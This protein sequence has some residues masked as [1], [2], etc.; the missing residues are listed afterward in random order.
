MADGR[1]VG[2]Y[3]KCHN[4]PNNRPTETQ[5]GWSHH[6]TSSTCPP[7]FGCYGNSR[8]LETANWTLC[9][10]GHLRPNAWTNCDEIQ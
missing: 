10:Y 9:N 8:C 6:N 5:V 4:S 1:H 7:R 3:S 2:K